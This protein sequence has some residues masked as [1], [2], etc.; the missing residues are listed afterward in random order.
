MSINI[1]Q[2]AKDFLRSSVNQM[3][4]ESAVWNKEMIIILIS[5]TLGFGL[6]A[7]IMATILLY[8]KECSG[9]QILQVFG[10]III[11]VFSVVLIIV[12]YSQSQL[13]PVIGLFG[14]I[15]GYLLGRGSTMQ[16]PTAA[17]ENCEENSNDNASSNNA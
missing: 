16:N 10:I 3:A 15:A 8:K 9:N 13:T 5:A 2:A 7:L 17:S 4:K 12:G 14:A 11:V 6:I 1:E